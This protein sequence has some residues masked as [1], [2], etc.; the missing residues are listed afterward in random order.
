MKAKTTLFGIVSLFM[1]SSLMAQYDLAIG[2]ISAGWDTYNPSTGIINGVTF[3]VLNNESDN[4]GSFDVRV[5]L[6]DPDNSS[7]SYVVWGYIDT[8]GQ[9]GNTVVTYN[10]IDIDFNDTP[11]IP[12]GQY[13]LAVCVDPDNDISETDETNNCLYIST[14]GN[15][16]TYNP[17]STSID[18]ASVSQPVAIYPN[19]VE[20]F[21]QVQNNL[22]L[23]KV[24]LVV[25][26]ISGK[27]I[28]SSVL[29]SLVTLV[30]MNTV[31]PGLYI[32]QIINNDGK[33]ISTG[34]LV[35]K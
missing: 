17:G 33:V 28:Q 27:T 5:Y 35:K 24:D 2:N 1:G 31:A 30:D 13:R 34:K 20:D 6:V 15:H 11:G 4:P 25:M 29:S 10:N 12:A 19:P 23:D 7:I 14:P 32:Y 26:D 9:G 16:L 22:S 8:D 18:G 3:D 21:M